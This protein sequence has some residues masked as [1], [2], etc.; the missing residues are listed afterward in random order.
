VKIIPAGVVF[1]ALMV[2]PLVAQSHT[3]E[4]PSHSRTYPEQKKQL[5]AVYRG[6]DGSWSNS[7]QPTSNADSLKQGLCSTAPAFCADYH[8]GNGG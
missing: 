8:G 5:R 1:A 7:L 6:L 2:S 4:G 3:T